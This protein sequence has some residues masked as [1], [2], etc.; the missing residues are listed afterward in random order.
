M[1]WI[2]VSEHVL[3]FAGMI[4]GLPESAISNVVFE[5]VSISAVTGM[6]IENAK[7]VRFKNSTVKADEG[8]PFVV[9]NAD[10][11]NH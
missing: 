4:F 11:Q 1:S 7:G 10:V 8:E 9:K 2:S 3:L 5:S 6:K